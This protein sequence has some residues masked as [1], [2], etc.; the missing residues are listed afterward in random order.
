MATL[1]NWRSCVRS[2][3]S[4]GAPSIR[5][6][7]LSCLLGNGLMLSAGG[8]A[9]EDSKRLT[10]SFGLGYCPMLF[11]DTALSQ[12]VGEPW[13]RFPLTLEFEVQTAP[14]RNP[15][16]LAVNGS[17][18]FSNLV[19]S[20]PMALFGEG[21]FGILY[22]YPPAAPVGLDLGIHLGIGALSLLAAGRDALSIPVGVSLSYSFTENFYMKILLREFWRGDMSFFSSA[23]IA[24]FR[25][26]QPDKAG[27]QNP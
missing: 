10:G 7:L 18:V 27:T 1:F 21:T 6:F 8:H 24:G 19:N 20:R 3:R 14:D 12:F 16:R 13:G 17:L 9:S 26:Y 23:L 15:V 11:S 25:I 2:P 22:R 4:R 5:A